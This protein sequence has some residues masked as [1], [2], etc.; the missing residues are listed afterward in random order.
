[1]SLSAL[2]RVEDEAVTFRSHLD[3]AMIELSPERAIEVQHLL[4]SDIAMQLDEC[5]E[6]PAPHNERCSCHAALARL[7]GAEQ[8][9]IQKAPQGRALFGIVQGGDDMRLRMESAQALIDIGFHGYA[10][11]GLGSGRAT[12]GD[13]ANGRGSWLPCYPQLSRATSWASA[14]RRTSSRRVAR[15]IDMFD[16][17]M[18]TRN[19]APR[20]CLHPLRAGQSQECPSCRRSATDR[21]AKLLSRDTRLFPGVSASPDES[22]RDAGGDPAHQ[23]QS[24][25]L[26][27]ADG[28]HRSAISGRHVRGFP[29]CNR[30][31]LGARRCPLVLK[32]RRGSRRRPHAGAT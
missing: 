17:V 28:G 8:A 10:V 29:R 26:P 30:R 23:R 12:R 31:G 14:R 27:G 13:A 11:G 15:G 24:G 22:E 21:W 19:C 4:G 16:C 9:F 25:L 6:L 32:R 7:G 18:P 2:R 5:L 20:A 1:M 3:G